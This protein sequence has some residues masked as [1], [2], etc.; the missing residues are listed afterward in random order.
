M[1][2]I[3]NN[4]LFTEISAEESAIVSGG[5]AIKIGVSVP[6][7]IFALG[8]GQYTFNTT[9]NAVLALSVLTTQYNRSYASEI[10]FGF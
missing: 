8:A 1:Q 9:G 2:A 3:E 6:Q 4:T 7:Q 5:E 10:D